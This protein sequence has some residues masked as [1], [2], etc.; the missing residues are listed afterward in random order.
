MNARKRQDGKIRLLFIDAHV[1]W[2]RFV[3]RALAD[4]YEVM[5][6]L[7]FEALSEAR[8]GGEIELVFVGLSVAQESLSALSKLAANGGNHWHFVVLFPGR[9]DA[10][11][12]RV[13]LRSG[14]WDILGKPYDANTLRHVVEEELR[15]LERHTKARESRNRDD[16]YRSQ[17]SRLLE[18]VAQEGLN[19]IR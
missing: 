11:T 9:P 6:C 5:T 8:E 7:E 15:I 17:V 18:C 16:S 4:S 13:L 12:A 14:V 1:E 2:L 10:Q 3:E 19:G